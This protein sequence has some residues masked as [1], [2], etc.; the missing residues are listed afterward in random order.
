MTLINNRTLR[1][2]P[3]EVLTLIESW[4][5]GAS[6]PDQRVIAM[7]ISKQ[8]LHCETHCDTLQFPHE[9]FFSVCGE[10]SRLEEEYKG[11]GR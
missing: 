11:R 1:K 6:V 3:S 10:A 5:P 2:S 7:I 8:R 9:I 4:K